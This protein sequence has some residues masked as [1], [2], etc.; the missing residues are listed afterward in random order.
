MEYK[1][2]GGI[3]SYE[4]KRWLLNQIAGEG[5]HEPSND[6]QTF[7]FLYCL[8]AAGDP[9]FSEDVLQMSFYRHRRNT[10]LAGDFLV[11]LP[12]GQ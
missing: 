10:E 9:E 8:A 12:L 3:F 4:L 2:V 1:L 6:M 11:L 5:R 7:G